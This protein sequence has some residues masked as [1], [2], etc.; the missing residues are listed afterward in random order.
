MVKAS[1]HAS[2]KRLHF[3][4]N[5]CALRAVRWLTRLVA[6]S[7]SECRIW[8]DFGVAGMEAFLGEQLKAALVTL[9]CHSKTAKAT[10]LAPEIGPNTPIYRTAMLGAFACC[11]LWS[12][13]LN[14][15]L[16]AHR[17]SAIFGAQKVAQRTAHI[18]AA[19]L[20]VAQRQQRPAAGWRA[21]FAE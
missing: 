3:E 10:L 19:A 15:A 2:V 8:V 14:P 6:S 1:L 18:A 11:A 9:L 13:T 16:G 20:G 5:R 4:G 12:S 21:Q 7:E 17:L